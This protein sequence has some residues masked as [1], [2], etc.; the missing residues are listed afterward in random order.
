VAMDTSME[1]QASEATDVNNSKPSDASVDSGYETATMD[2]SVET[3]NNSPLNTSTSV[4]EKGSDLSTEGG[5]ISDAS[6]DDY[7]KSLVKRL[8]QVE[9]ELKELKSGE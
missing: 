1:S 9:N 8:E 5:A 3:P 4:A 2:T 6:E 7:V